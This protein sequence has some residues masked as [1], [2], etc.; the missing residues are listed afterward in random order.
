MFPKVA[1][2]DDVDGIAVVDA[3]S[4]IELDFILQT[5]QKEV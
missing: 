1:L 3:V 2:N 4:D 5:R